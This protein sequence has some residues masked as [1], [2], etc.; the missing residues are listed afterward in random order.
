MLHPVLVKT[1]ITSFVKLTASASFARAT[2][3][4]T[5]TLLPSNLTRNSVLPSA[6][7]VKRG[8]CQATVRLSP[9]LIDALAETSRVTPSA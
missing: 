5:T 4:G 3:T 9:T 2:L 7:G 1:G 8:A 6:N